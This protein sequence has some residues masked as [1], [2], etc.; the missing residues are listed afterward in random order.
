MVFEAHWVNEVEWGCKGRGEAVEAEN[1]A[2]EAEWGHGGWDKADEA[3]RGHEG[4]TRP[5]RPDEAMEAGIRLLRP[6][7]AIGGHG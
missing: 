1:E 2:I 5:L 7:K 6:N 3:E 4:Q